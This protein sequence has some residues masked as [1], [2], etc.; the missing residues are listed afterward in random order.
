MM[1]YT[2]LIPVANFLLILSIAALQAYNAWQNAKIKSAISD[3]KVYVH[4]HFVQK[5]EIP[6]LAK[7]R[8]P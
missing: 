4:E 7:R 3:L 5:D 6:E 2:T 8:A 1:I